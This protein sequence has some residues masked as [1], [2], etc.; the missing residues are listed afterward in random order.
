MGSMLNTIRGLCVKSNITLAELERELGFS[1][2]SLWKWEKSPPS[3]TK[4]E[5]VAKYF[6]VSV[7]YL[8]GRTQILSVVDEALSDPDI[9]TIQRLRSRLS[10]R[11]R[12]K[13]M[14]ML[15]IQFAEDF[16]E[17]EKSY[18]L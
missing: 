1:A 17:E 18:G 2:A 9:A 3:I 7:D 5:M 14:A 4:V 8:I 13:M 11:D 15:Y 12:R 10:D 6:E 16:P